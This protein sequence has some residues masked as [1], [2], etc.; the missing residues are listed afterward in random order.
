MREH[1]RIFTLPDSLCFAAVYHIP[2]KKVWYLLSST[3]SLAFISGTNGFSFGRRGQSGSCDSGR[4][5]AFFVES[6]SFYEVVIS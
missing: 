3:L 6:K 2:L 4:P 5:L 1:P